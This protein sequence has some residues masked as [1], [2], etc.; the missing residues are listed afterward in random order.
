MSA[1]PFSSLL[2]M[3]PTIYA[4]SSL[5]HVKIKKGGKSDP[6]LSYS[7]SLPKTKMENYFLG[8]NAA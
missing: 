5:E 7:I 8:A 2:R 3:K 4:I 6:P 1:L